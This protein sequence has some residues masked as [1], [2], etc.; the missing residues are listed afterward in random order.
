MEF[1]GDRIREWNRAGEDSCD[2]SRGS[3]TSRDRRM[4]DLWMGAGGRRG[5][6]SFG[7]R[8]S[9]RSHLSRRLRRSFRRR[10]RIGSVRAVGHGQTSS[11]GGVKERRL[12]AAGSEGPRCAS[13]RGLM[14][15][16]ITHRGFLPHQKM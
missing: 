13:R 9:H 10:D 16:W 7:A 15:S 3:S 5:A 8:R 1:Q 11:G 14:T 4:G 12:G 6:A 2:R